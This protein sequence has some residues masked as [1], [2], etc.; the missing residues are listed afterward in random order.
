M[1]TQ[2]CTILRAIMYQGKRLEVG[3][4]HE[5][6]AAFA[7][8]CHSVKKVAYVPDPVPQI[9]TPKVPEPEKKSEPEAPKGSK[10]AGKSA[11]KGEK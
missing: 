11:G 4:V 5:L 1:K 8:E 10:P 9:D 7:A 2:R 6:P 3:T